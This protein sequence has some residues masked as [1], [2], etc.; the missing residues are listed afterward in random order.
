MMRH[1]GCIPSAQK[2]DYK[3]K[4]VAGFAV[5][6][7]VSS[8]AC[9]SD[10]SAS[11]PLVLERASDRSPEPTFDVDKDLEPGDQVIDLGDWEDREEGYERPSPCTL[12]FSMMHSWADENLSCGMC[13]ALMC[14]GDLYA[15]VC[16]HQCDGTREPS[17]GDPVPLI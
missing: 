15:H 7:L 13:F 4:S 11:G 5:L 12:P 1:G 6:L 17:G 9:S 8:A 2:G 3:M 16:T 14:N 10:D